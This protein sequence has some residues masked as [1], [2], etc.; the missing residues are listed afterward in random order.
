MSHYVLGSDV[1][2]HKGRLIR[3][4][5][6]TEAAD[7]Y[8]ERINNVPKSAFVTVPN[9]LEFRPDLLANQLYT[10]P[11]KLWLVCLASNRFDVFED[12]DVNAII[13]II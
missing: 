10:N 1:Y 3:T 11:D 2:Y 13:N 12:F 9:G 7:R 8:V 4:T 6:G 5:V